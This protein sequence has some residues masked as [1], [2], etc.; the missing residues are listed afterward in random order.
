M[1]CMATF[2][3]GGL[4]IVYGIADI[5]GLFDISVRLV[6]FETLTKI[7]SVAPIGLFIGI[8]FGFFFGMLRA[9]EL[10]YRGELP[11]DNEE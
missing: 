10:H 7:M 1:I 11:I 9:V 5:E 8:A 4:G 2:M 3:G 6:Y